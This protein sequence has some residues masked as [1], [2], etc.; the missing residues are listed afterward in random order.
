MKNGGGQMFHMKT[1]YPRKRQHR[2]S[3]SSPCTPREW[4]LT[5]V[6]QLLILLFKYVYM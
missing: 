6:F 1:K 2:K 4:L 3:V 5:T